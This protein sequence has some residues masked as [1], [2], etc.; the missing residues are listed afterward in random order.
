[1]NPRDEAGTGNR[2]NH[3]DCAQ[4]RMHFA[5]LLYGELS[6]DEEERVDAH[7]DGCAA[8]RR[9]LERQRALHTAFD[10]FAVEPPAALLRECRADLAAALRLGIS[11]R[12]EKQGWWDRMT[13]WISAPL[14][15]PAGAFALVLLGFVGAKLLPNVG[16]GILGGTIFS[17][18]NQA[19]LARVSDVEAQSD[20]SVR[21]VVDQTQRRTIT[22]GL[23]DQRIRTLLLD[24]ARDPNNPG[25]RADS[26]DLLTRRAQSAEIRGTLVDLVVHD[27]NDG[28]RLKAMEGLKPYV[29]DP[30]VRGALS[31]ALLGDANP[32][33][34]TQA[35]DLLIEAPAGDSMPNLDRAT[36]GML[37]QLM[38][39]ERNASVRQ[40]A[41]R[42]L[43]LVN[44]S[45]EI[46]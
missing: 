7:L 4:A 44:A 6:F 12:T 17:S 22:G 45:P 34:R 21:V 38:S 9:D 29:T 15:R 19:G 40:R 27:Q 39:Q 46:N 23:D 35:I 41:E 42:V 1:M 14:L 37:Q 11:P 8:C 26:V 10:E 30:E 32:G 31:R 28:V 3:I 5:L 33:V 2:D 18:A 36:I 43:E 13:G 25:L 24:A 16:D 20:G